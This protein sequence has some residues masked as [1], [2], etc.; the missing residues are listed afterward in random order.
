MLYTIECT[1]MG[2]VLWI[3]W[4]LAY[5]CKVAF[6]PRLASA[7]TWHSWLFRRASW[8]CPRPVYRRSGINFWGTDRSYTEP[9]HCLQL[10]RSIDRPV[11]SIM[12]LNWSVDRPV[13]SIMQLNR[14]VDLI[15]FDY[16]ENFATESIIKRFDSIRFCIDELRSSWSWLWAGVAPHL[17]CGSRGRFPEAPSCVGWSSPGAP[18]QSIR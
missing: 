4:R 13:D 18:A 2:C 10:N 12:Q 11:D 5:R 6:V 16:A 8:L 1:V 15:R 17:P 9:Y 7:G 3:R 14:L